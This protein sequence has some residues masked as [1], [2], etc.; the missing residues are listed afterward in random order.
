MSLVR[1]RIVMVREHVPCGV[2]QYVAVGFRVR[3]SSGSFADVVSWVESTHG[4]CVVLFVADV[5][6]VRR[7]IV[8]TSFRGKVLIS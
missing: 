8:L 2:I 4:S 7:L 3:E 5:D 6:D 1:S